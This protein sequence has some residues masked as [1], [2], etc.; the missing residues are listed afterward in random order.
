MKQYRIDFNFNTK[1]F[2]E[3]EKNKME[4]FVR[5]LINQETKFKLTTYG[6]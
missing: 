2:L 5:N 6:V 4:R 3:T 1:Y